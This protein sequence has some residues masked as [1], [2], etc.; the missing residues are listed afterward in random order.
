RRATARMPTFPATFDAAG[1]TIRMFDHAVGRLEVRQRSQPGGVVVEE[2]L[3]ED[4]FD[5]GRL[6]QSNEV[7]LAPDGT[8]Q[9][10][11]N[12]LEWFAGTE[13]QSIWRTG[14]FYR[15]LVETVDGQCVESMLECEPCPPNERI[16]FGAAELARHLA[17][18]EPRTIG[19]ENERLSFAAYAGSP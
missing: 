2:K 4:R 18:S 15:A 10:P 7:R 12:T 1:F 5:G 19:L 16:S 14:N 11:G 17:A 8:L 9:D 3:A 6:Y 13:R